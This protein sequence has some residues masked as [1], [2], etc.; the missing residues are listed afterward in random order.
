MLAALVGL[1]MLGIVPAFQAHPL[2]PTLGRQ[3]GP[4]RRA[5]TL[6]VFSLPGRPDQTRGPYYHDSPS[7]HR[8]NLRYCSFPR[9]RLAGPRRL[10]TRFARRYR[11]DDGGISREGGLGAAPAWSDIFGLS[12]EGAPVFA[13]GRRWTL[14]RS[15]T[16]GSCATATPAQ[17]YY[18]GGDKIARWAAA[19]EHG[20]SKNFPADVR[21]G[22]SRPCRR[23]ALP[24][25]APEL[26]VGTGHCRGSGGHSVGSSRWR[27]S[28]GLDI[29]R[30]SP[31]CGFCCSRRH[32]WPSRTSLEFRVFWLA[33]T[34]VRL[35]LWR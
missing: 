29:S 23:C 17:A 21:V 8:S 35:L 22:V 13:T 4:G 10:C 12:V 6:V 33:G 7:G 11:R 34:T 26:G 9:R 31:F 24:P 2:Y 28:L 16:S 3:L 30:W 18:G 32:S 27:S 14:R 25:P 1:L 5:R 15:R 20:F 19:A